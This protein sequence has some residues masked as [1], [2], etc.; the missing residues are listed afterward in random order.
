MND[1]QDE[2]KDPK[3]P[4]GANPPKAPKPFLKRGNGKA[5]GVGKNATAKTPVRQSN[6]Q[7]QQEYN[8]SLNQEYM[9]DQSDQQKQLDDFKSLEERAREQSKN[10]Q[11]TYLNNQKKNQKLFDDDSEEEVQQPIKQEDNRSNLVKK[12]FYKDSSTP[13]L[14]TK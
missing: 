13:N 11:N 12:M 3:S 1:D 7:S 6:K 9:Y 14:R 2:P 8:N 10:L 5:G 4:S